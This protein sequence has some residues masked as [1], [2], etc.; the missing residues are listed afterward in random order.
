ML[1]NAQK[2]VMTSCVERFAGFV[3]NMAAA[4]PDVLDNVD[5]DEMVDEYADM[6]G[7][8]PKVIVPI[9]KVVQLRAQ[10]NQQAAQDRMMQQTMAGVE[11]AKTLSDT[12]V[13]GGRNALEAMIGG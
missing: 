10:R 7:I 3:G 1:A 11:G 8:S 9:A 13:G 5:W 12:Q 6:L 2:G 4:R